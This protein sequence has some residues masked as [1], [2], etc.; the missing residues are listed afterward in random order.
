MV[1]AESGRLTRE[2]KERESDEKAN[3]VT[4]GGVFDFSSVSAGFGGHDGD[5][6]RRQSG[7]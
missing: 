6:G 2:K 4:D 5:G 3:G 1:E 7:G